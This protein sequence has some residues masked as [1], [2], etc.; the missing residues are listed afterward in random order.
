[1]GGIQLGALAEKYPE[2]FEKHY[3]GDIQLVRSTILES[4]AADSSATR[5]LRLALIAFGS[6]EAAALRHEILHKA[7]LESLADGKPQTI[8]QIIAG[9]SAGLGLPRP[10][11]T[12]LLVKVMA[13]EEREGTV[14]REQDS[15]VVTEFGKK[16]LS[17]VPVQATAH[18]LEGRAI[19]RACL[20]E[21]IGKQI[22]DSQY[23]QLWSGLVD[24]LAGLFHANG[25][26]VIRSVEQ[27]LSGRVDDSHEEPNLRALLVDGIKRTVSVVSTPELRSTAELAMSDLFTERSGPAFDWFT[28]VAERFV[29]LCSLG[30]EATSGDEVR[31]AIG[32]HQIILDSDIILSYLCRA[33]VDHP[34]SRDLLARW[35][36]AGGRILVAPVV[37]EEVAYHAWISERDFRET[38][39]LLGKLKKHEL[40]RYIKSAFVRTYHVLEKTANRWPEYIGQFR[41]NSSGDYTKILSMLRLRLKVET[42]PEVFDEDVRKGISG[43]LMTLARE[44]PRGPEQLEDISYKVERDGKLMASIASARTAQERM[45]ADRPIVLLSSSYL[46]RCA[47]NRFRQNFGAAKVLIS[48]GALSYLL[49]RSL[50][51]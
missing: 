25:L 32:A 1:M 13:D 7:A 12:E 14:R 20:E 17:L 33:E 34:R 49:S 36:Q 26:A 39:Y 22:S 27:F 38:E 8:R 24:F 4:P 45:G 43:Y 40:A 11:R 30:L 51:T 47:E 10:L 42:L 35:L 28:K 19:I 31:R 15:F 3:R 37:L 9:F 16:Q 5:G 46:L 29:I 21:L 6:D 2:I 18:L 50:T 48:I 41:G 44:F 23:E